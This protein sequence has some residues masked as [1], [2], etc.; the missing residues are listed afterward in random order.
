[1]Q[2]LYANTFLSTDIIAVEKA[3][4]A[5]YQKSRFFRVVNGYV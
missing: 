2:E 4:L 3:V 1:M 5:E